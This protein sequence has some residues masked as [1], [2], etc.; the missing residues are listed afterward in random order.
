[1][2]SRLTRVPR[3]SLRKDVDLDPVIHFMR[4]M[5]EVDHE[6]QRVSKRM[7]ATVGLT[8]PQRLA[9]LIISHYPGIS[10]GELANWL[11]LDP[12]TLTGI[13]ARLEV[14]KLIKRTRDENDGRRAMLTLTARGRSANRR[15]A[16]T[17]ES[18]VRR[19]L[20]ETRAADAEATRRM[21]SRLAAALR[22]ALPAE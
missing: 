14:A 7:V 4:L 9:L 3:A 6:L 21:L 11:H 16:G 19:A 20:D 8:G 22:R 5:W 17:V 12:G 10:A 13:I 15:R 2:T 18:A 1:M